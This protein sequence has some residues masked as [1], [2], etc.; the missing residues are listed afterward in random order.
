MNKFITASAFVVALGLSTSALASGFTGPQQAG[1]FQG[2]G[3]APS[4]VAEALKLNDD[5]PVV[6]VGQIEKSLGDEKYLF[7]DASGS[8]TVEIDN[9]D[10]RGVTVT[11][12]DT[13]VLQGEI[14]KDFFKTE[15]DVDSVAL[16]NKL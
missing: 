9:E 12:K 8:V 11:P 14:D 2:P 10:W 13:I 3:L 1:G 4:S 6:L 5:T 16:K 15:I 7:K